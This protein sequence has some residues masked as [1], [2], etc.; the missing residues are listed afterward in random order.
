M[1]SNSVRLRVFVALFVAAVS[2]VATVPASATHWAG[3]GSLSPYN[4]YQGVATDF[5][6]TLVNAA[7][8]SADIYWV[9]ASFC[10]NP[11]N[12]GYYFKADDG[13][14]VSIPA[15][16]SHS[17]PDR[18]QVDQ[19]TLGSCSVSVQVN[20]VAAGDILGRAT[21]TYSEVIN[22]VSIPPL[23]VSVAANPNNGQANLAVSFSATVTGGLAPYTYSWTFGD[24][25]TDAT[26]NPSHTYTQAGTYTV[27]LVVTDSQNNQKSGTTTVTVTSPFFG[28]GVGSSGGLLVLIGVIVL[29]VVVAAVAVAVVMR[30]RR[31]PRPPEQRPPMPPAPPQ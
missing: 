23:Q 1:R 16:S 7:S 3:S 14:S 19:S 27:T 11:T 20:G 26:A 30:R 22:V 4:V 29:V 15:G 28:G 8:S 5:S 2:L 17:F 6:F 31:T 10:W 13:T 21:A 12:F 24:G 25:G 18:I 9:F